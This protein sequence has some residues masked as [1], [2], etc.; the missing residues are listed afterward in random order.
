MVPE[1]MELLLWEGQINKKEAN[2]TDKTTTT[3][4]LLITNEIEPSNHFIY[5]FIIYMSS[6]SF[7]LLQF[8]YRGFCGFTFIYLNKM[9]DSI[10][11]VS[12][13]LLR[14]EKIGL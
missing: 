8:S 1:L 12:S 11:Y 10:F 14:E 3:C 13:H 2:K 7:H 4:I 6:L 5:F 9:R